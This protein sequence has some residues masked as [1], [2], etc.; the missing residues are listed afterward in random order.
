M[1]RLKDSKLEISSLLGSKQSVYKSD[2]AASRHTATCTQQEDPLQH[3]SLDTGNSGNSA[4][5]REHATGQNC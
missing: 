3:D 2:Q 1:R 5:T 4:G